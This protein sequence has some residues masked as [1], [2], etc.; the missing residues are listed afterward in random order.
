MEVLQKLTA[1]IEQYRKQ[2][3]AAAGAVLLLALLL[4]LFAP[5]QTSDYQSIALLLYAGNAAAT[6][7]APALSAIDAAKARFDDQQLENVVNQFD[8]YPELRQKQSAE[9]VVAQMRERLSLLQPDNYSLQIAFRDTN[10]ERSQEVANALAEVLQTDV[11]ARADV[12][13]VEGPGERHIAA[14]NSRKKYLPQQKPVDDVRRQLARVNADLAALTG[15]Q[16]ELEEKSADKQRQIAAA[17]SKT[18]NTKAVESEPPVDPYASTRTT[19]REQ[20][21]AEK[22]QLA[23]LLQRYTEAYPDVIDAHE[24]IS[25]LETKLA[26]LPPPP[27]LH[28]TRALNLYQR[29]IDDLTAEESKIGEQLRSNERDIADLQR[30]RSAL[31]QQ[32]SRM[33]DADIATDAGATTANAIVPAASLPATEQVHPFHILQGATMSV[34]V[35]SAKA[36][37]LTPAVLSLASIGTVAVLLLFLVPLVPFKDLVITTPEE[38]RKS[39]PDHVIYLGSVFGSDH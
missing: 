9:V 10:S 14:R 34:A 15:R 25:Q 32:I 27:A 12:P 19:L 23:N 7:G 26:D 33:P 30:R 28:R 16:S 21:A 20:L 3:F 11:L 17:G 4:A 8:L 29:E 6:P 38:L 13:R 31:L 1:R 18:G 22:Q 5:G 35:G 2:A 36:T 24:Q 39:L 37:R